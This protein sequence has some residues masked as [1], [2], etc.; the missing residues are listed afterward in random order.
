MDWKYL[1][2]G[3]RQRLGQNRGLKKWDGFGRQWDRKSSEE[4]TE[5]GKR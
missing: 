5:I 3:G 2:V 1:D 4:A